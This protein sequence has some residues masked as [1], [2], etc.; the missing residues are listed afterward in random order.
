M[1]LLF[2]NQAWGRQ[3]I[4]TIS[5]WAGDPIAGIRHQGEGFAGFCLLGGRPEHFHRGPGRKNAMNASQARLLTKS[6]KRFIVP[7]SEFEPE[8]LSRSM[9]ARMRPVI[10]ALMGAAL[11]C[12]AC[13]RTPGGK[14]R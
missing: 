1:V 9:E 13:T 11:G 3:L 4:V 6:M 12:R 14:A 2:C 8:N 7:W 5:R 10:V